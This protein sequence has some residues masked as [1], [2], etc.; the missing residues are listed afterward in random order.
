MKQNLP[1]SHDSKIKVN[2]IFK[3]IQIV[4]YSINSFRHCYLL[5]MPLDKPVVSIHFITVRYFFLMPPAD[6]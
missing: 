5:V 6:D 4:A 3:E 2:K 1:H